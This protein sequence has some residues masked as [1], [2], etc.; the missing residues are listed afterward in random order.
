MGP[1]LILD[2]SALQT[3]S[4]DEVLF[5]YKFFTVNVPHILI[6]EIL[7]DLKK[8]KLNGGEKQEVVTL[9]NKFLHDTNF[10]VYYRDMII[11]SL[12]GKDQKGDGRP[13]LGGGENVINEKGEKGII[14]GHTPE[15]EA[16]DR[17]RRGQF[18]EGEDLVAEKWREVI[19]GIDLEGFKKIFKEILGDMPKLK[20]LEEV[21]EYTRSIITAEKSQREVLMQ[22]IYEFGLEDIGSFVF[23][24]WE[25]EGKPPID[26]FAPYASF[27][28]RINIFFK[29]GLVFN[30]IGT[31]STNQFDLEYLYYLPFCMA[32]VSRDKFH[33]EVTHFFLDDQRD[34]SFID[35]DILKADLGALATERNSLDPGARQ[36]WNR[37]YH[38]VPPDREGS[39]VLEMW[40]KYMDYEKAKKS[41]PFIPTRDTDKANELGFSLNATPTEERFGV[42]EANYVIRK[43]NIRLSDMCLCSSGEQFKDC[44]GRLIWEQRQKEGA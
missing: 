19:K 33:K 29:I 1:I 40:K 8:E 17:W 9:A 42:D 14:F 23:Q 30:L 39:I 11:G 5:L 21:Y 12:M 37:T 7:A 28:L 32:F 6:L 35:G 4:K 34:Q 13:V 27:C 10:N 31:R 15:E 36:E 38:M 16:L 43:T 3:L 22:L 41:K 20:T 18:Q 44:C 2:K 26:V 25:H 24:R